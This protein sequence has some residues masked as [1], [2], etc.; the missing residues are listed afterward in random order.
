MSED[1]W[2]NLSSGEVEVGHR[3][4]HSA[5]MGPYPTREA[6]R[7][8]LESAKARTEAWDAADED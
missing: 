5:L 8:A 7:S 2:Y 1:Y 6:A 4:D 3:S